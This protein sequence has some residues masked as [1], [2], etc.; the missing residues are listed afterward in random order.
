M[1]SSGISVGRIG[2]GCMP[3]NWAYGGESDEAESFRAIHRALELGMTLLDT[4]DV[5]GPYTNEDLVGRAL[6]RS[7]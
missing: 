2:L 4:A 1:G 3:M 7:P 6:T 5:Y